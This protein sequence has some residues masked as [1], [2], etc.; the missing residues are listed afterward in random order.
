M[1]QSDITIRPM[2]IDD[3][4]Q[5]YA[6]WEHINGFALRSVDDSREGIARFLDRNPNSSVVAELNG[7][8][9]GSI[10]CGHDGRQGSFY[11]VCVSPEF[12]KHGIGRSMVRASLKALADEH[13][14]KVTLVA[15]SSN[16][17]GNAFWE[18]IGW[19]RRPDYNSY[20]FRLNENNIIRFVEDAAGEAG[21][22]GE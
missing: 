6:L 11:H 22:T 8:V 20:E 17:G 19:T 16:E 15:F 21:N 4:D 5:V 3:Y 13:V 12:R 9:I 10:L 18:H 2:T 14:S 1:T 7:Q